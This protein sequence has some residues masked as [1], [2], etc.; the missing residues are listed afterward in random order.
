MKGMQWTGEP[1]GVNLPVL[2]PVLLGLALNPLR[3]HPTHD[4]AATDDGWMAGWI[5]E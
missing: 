1:S 5:D 2:Q 4:E 3:P